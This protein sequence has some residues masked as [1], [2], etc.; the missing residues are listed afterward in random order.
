MHFVL[1]LMSMAVAPP[2]AVPHAGK[3]SPE[4]GAER[5]AERNVDKKLGEGPVDF[6]CDNMFVYSK[7]NRNVCR[8]NVVVRRG[9]MLICCDV[10]EGQADEQWTWQSFTCS[11]DVRAQRGIETVWAD[12]AEFFQQRSDLIL[13]GKPLLQRGDSVLEG[14]RVMMNVKED[15]ARVIQARGRMDMGKGGSKPLPK[16]VVEMPVGPLPATCPIP[17]VAR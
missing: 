16:S 4:R 17:A 5:G 10:F 15:Q 14:E 11:G 1:L 6:R 2:A 3:A 12:K 8:A 9:T 13:T 7:P